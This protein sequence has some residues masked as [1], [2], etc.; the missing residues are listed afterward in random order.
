MKENDKEWYSEPFSTHNMGYKICLTTDTAGDGS[1]R[2]THLSVFLMLMKGSHD[3]ELRWPLRGEFEIKLFNQISDSEHRSVTVTFDD[4]TDGPDHRVMEGDISED[5]WGRHV[6]TL[7]P[8]K[9]SV[10]LYTP[11]CQ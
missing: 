1:S 2:G 11:T 6:L 5:G 7:F 3:D 10:T 8:M 9:T 4:N